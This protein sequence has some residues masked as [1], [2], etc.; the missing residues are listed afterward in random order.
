MKEIK[1]YMEL[2]E[3]CRDCP[4]MN[5]NCFCKLYYMQNQNGD[6]LDCKDCREKIHENCP[7]VDIKIHDRELVKEVCEK[8]KQDCWCGGA[9]LGDDYY[10]VPVEYLENLQKEVDSG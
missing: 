1:V 7:L 6:V 5:S 3:N 2:P 10:K 9:I 4:C 8:I